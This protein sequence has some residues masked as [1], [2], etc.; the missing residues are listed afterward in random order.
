MLLGCSTRRVGL[1]EKPKPPRKRVV[2][3]TCRRIHS[4]IQIPQLARTDRHSL[5]SVSANHLP[6]TDTLRPRSAAKSNV[7]PARKGIQPCWPGL[8]TFLSDCWKSRSGSTAVHHCRLL[9]QG[10]DTP[11][12]RCSRRSMPRTQ[13]SCWSRTWRSLYYP[14]RWGSWTARSASGTDGRCHLREQVAVA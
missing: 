2:I 5:I 7:V 1:R 14:C 12:S 10:E 8:S 6:V 3:S 11:R 13:R 9:Q 4:L